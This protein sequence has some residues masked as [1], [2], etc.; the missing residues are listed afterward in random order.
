MRQFTL[1]VALAAPLAVHGHGL[2]RATPAAPQGAVLAASDDGSNPLLTDA[3]LP[4]FAAIRPEHA[5]PAVEARLADGALRL[6]QMEARLAASLKESDKA[7]AYDDLVLPLEDMYDHVSA[8]WELV[9]HLKSVRDSP[10]YRSA[11]EALQPKVIAF[12][13]N[14]SQ[15]KPIYEA[16]ERLDKAEG[17]SL[18]EARQRIL[19]KELLDRKL[20]GVGLKGEDAAEFNQAQRHLSDLSTSFS[21]HLLDAR[22]G[23]NMTVTDPAV[24]KGVPARTLAGAAAAAKKAGHADATAEKGPWVLTLDGPTLGPV[25]TYAEDRALREKLL[26]ASATLASSGKSDNM[27]TVS[28]ILEQRQLQASLLGYSD[29]AALSFASKMATKEGVHKLLDKLQATGRP[30]AQKEDKELEAFAQNLSKIGEIQPWDRSYYVEKLRRDRYGLDAEALRAY[31][32]L[33]NVLQGLFSL[34]TRLFGVGFKEASAEESANSKWHADVMLYHVTRGGETIGH[35]LIDPYSR[36]AEK[37]AGAWLQP[38]ISRKATA[39]GVRLPS[40]AVVMN[41][42]PPAADSP[43]LLSLGEVGTLFH[44]FGHGLQHVLTVQNETAVAGI[45]GVEW[46]AVEVASQFMEYWVDFDKQTLL[47]MAKHYKTGEALPEA[48]YQQIVASREFRAGAMLLGQIYLG[49][50]DLTLHEKFAKGEDTNA[51]EKGVADTVLIAKP[52]P[53]ARPLCSFSHIFSGGYAAGYY[54]YQWSKVLSADAFSAFDEGG[55]LSDEAKA[56][57]IGQRLASTLLALGGGRA[58]AKVF[59]DFRGHDAGDPT[60]LLRYS[61]LLPAGGK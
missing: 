29:Y 22:N 44:E 41:F 38:M 55:G 5:K 48:M 31:F 52:L 9:N 46:D 49:K 54:S 12:W 19:Q 7:V 53:E 42:P 14:V 15:S 35:V 13:Q 20:G 39:N 58:P 18:P 8:P 60:A 2:R 10:E 21:N 17:A 4:P 25:I 6:A 47:G 11:V 37:R 40:G 24:V 27:A 45:N 50:V 28:Q 59:R 32:T 26:R 1:L 56:R 23:W 30:A 34:S 43:S 51:I 33:P 36:P 16:L 61:G 57:D 3:S